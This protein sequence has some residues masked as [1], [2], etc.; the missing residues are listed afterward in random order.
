[1]KRYVGIKQATV[2]GYA[3]MEIGGVA[4]FLYPSSKERRGRV[5]G[6]G[7]I[8]PTITAE[9]SGVCRVTDKQFEEENYKNLSKEELERAW[10]DQ[11]YR[12]RKLSPR[13]C[14]RLMDVLDSDI[15]KILSVNSSTQAYKQAGNSI[16]V[17]MLCAVYSQL[18]IK[19]IKPWNERTL[20]EKRQL[21][22]INN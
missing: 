20:E 6:N 3:V 7:Q 9:N 15:D 22:A 18:N 12:I 21:T 19:G 11:E 5:Q 17:N 14:L 2:K 10:K 4:D 16:V 1:M 13:E 8:C